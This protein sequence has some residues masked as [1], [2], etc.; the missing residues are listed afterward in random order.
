MHRLEITGVLLQDSPPWW[1]NFIKY[2]KNEYPNIKD[3]EF[4]QFTDKILYDEYGA[5][6][7]Y[8]E[9]QC[10]VSILDALLFN[11]EHTISWFLIKW[12]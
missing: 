9:S 10:G 4:T 5:I 7:V 12:S 1:Q 6:K 3:N 2:Y 11:N 8:G